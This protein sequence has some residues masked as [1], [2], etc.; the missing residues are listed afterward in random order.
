MNL[1]I[2]LINPLV[3]NKFSRQVAT[4]RNKQER[5]KKP[6][7]PGWRG[8]GWWEYVRGW[9]LAGGWGGWWGSCCWSARTA[10]PPCCSGGGATASKGRPPGWSDAPADRCR[11]IWSPQHSSPTRLS[12]RCICR[13][14]VYFDAAANK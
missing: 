11:S 5:W 14:E 4:S 10:R 8:G 2:N 6:Q 13:V 7:S 1:Q 3:R 12:R 9:V